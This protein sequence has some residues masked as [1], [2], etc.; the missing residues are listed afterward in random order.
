MQSGDIIKVLDLF[1]YK[2]RGYGKGLHPVDSVVEKVDF[3][4]MSL[5]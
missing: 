1:H 4:L 3:V 2:F 5:V